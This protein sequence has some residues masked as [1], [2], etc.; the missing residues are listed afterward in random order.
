[1]GQA[2][3]QLKIFKKSYQME[4]INRQD[5]VTMNVAGGANSSSSSISASST[6]ITI[7]ATISNGNPKQGSVAIWVG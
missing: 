6:N 2:L 3:K 4:K 5:L 1:M 7:K